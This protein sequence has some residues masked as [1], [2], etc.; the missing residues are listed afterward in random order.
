LKKIG[1]QIT[2]ENLMIPNNNKSQPFPIWVLNLERS[3]VRRSSMQE[4]LERLNLEYEFFQAVDGRSLSVEQL[5]LYSKTAALRNKHRELGRGEIGCAI[6]HAKMWQRLLDLDQEAIL[7]LEDDVLIGEMF[8]RILFELKDLPDD[9]DFITFKTD[10]VQVPFGE[11]FYDIY[12]FCGFSYPPNR[13]CAYLLSRSGAEK[14][15]DRIF[16]ISCPVDDYMGRSCLS[17]VNAYGVDPQVVAL[18]G[19]ASDIWIQDDY[20]SLERTRKVRIMKLFKLFL[21]RLGI[22]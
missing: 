18:N 9:W 5:G 10:S 11:P 6:S 19:E 12:R 3:T 7:V 4:Q 13:T 17:G 1:K 14:L 20:Y 22:R 8:Q 15:L 21:H 2:T 16:P